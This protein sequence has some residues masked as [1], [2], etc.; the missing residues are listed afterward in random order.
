MKKSNILNGGATS[1]LPEHTN[2][3]DSSPFIFLSGNRGGK[4]E[5]A[6]QAILKWAESRANHIGDLAPYQ[7]ALLDSFLTAGKWSGK[8]LLG[9]AVAER[10]EA[11]RLQRRLCRGRN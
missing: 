3:A 4:T 2:G 10:P 5:A 9:Q 1:R 8:V 11:G 6:K 7:E